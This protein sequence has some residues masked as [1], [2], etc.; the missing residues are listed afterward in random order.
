MV[1][2]IEQIE[3]MQANVEK[4]RQAAKDGPRAYVSNSIV[5]LADGQRALVRPLYNMDAVIVRPMHDK[6]KNTDVSLSSRKDQYGSMA[7]APISALCAAF[8]GKPCLFCAQPKDAKL[9]ARFEC[10]V[11]VYLFKVEQ[12]IDKVND[13]WEVVTYTDPEHNV[14]PV[15]GFRMLRLK[16]G[17]SILNVLM[18]TY[19]KD[20]YNRDITCCDFEIQRKGTGLDTDYTCTPNPPSAM[21]A[22]LKTAIPS[23]AKFQEVLQAIYPIKILEHAP[24]NGTGSEYSVAAIAEAV[25]N[26]ANTAVPPTAKTPVEQEPEFTF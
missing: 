24:V 3:A 5:L 1:S 8:D 11:P 2:T 4:A 7:A 23:I 9:E 10:F 22:N 6:Y 25:K 13:V 20:A 16:Q 12:L 14:K 15:K 21:S 18:A 26:G 19:K 17:S